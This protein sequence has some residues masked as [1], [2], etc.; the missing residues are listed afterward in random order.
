MKKIKFILLLTIIFSLT[1]CFNDDSMESI[2][3]STSVYPIEFVVNEL[4]GEH[5]KIYSI[6]P[7]DEEIV[8]FEV[9][10]TLLDQY[11]NS[12][13]FIFNGLSDESNYVKTM[14]KNNKDLKIIDVS[15]N[16][17]VNYSMEEIWL[18]P[19][20]LLTIANNIKKGFEEYISSSYLVKNVDELYEELKINLTALDGK[21][22]KTV[23]NSSNK[24]IIVN[25]NAFMYLKKYGLE[26]I[27]LDPETVTQ[28][29]IV[30]ALELLR[31]GTCNYVFINH[32]QTR[33]SIVDDIKNGAEFNTAEL[34]TMTNLSNVDTLKNDYIALMNQNLE[35]L[36]LELYK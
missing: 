31:N 17:Q 13:L 5:A 23:K 26:V 19:N 15:S 16:M 18:D 7:N 4:Y 34:F 24:T 27:S 3:I 6:Y 29:E 11:S 36:K 32:G 33:D 2:E 22:Y 1:G 14:L 35:A 21:Y 30:K 8:D 10:N 9:T 20:N 28:K 25:D 12:D